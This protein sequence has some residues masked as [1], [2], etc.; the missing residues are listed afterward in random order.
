MTHPPQ[1][2]DIQRPFF[3][4]NFTPMRMDS[5][6]KKIKKLKKN[7]ENFNDVADPKIV[8]SEKAGDSRG[9]NHMCTLNSLKK[10]KS[11]NHDFWPIF[12]IF[13]LIWKCLYYLMKLKKWQN[14][15]KIWPKNWKKSMKLQNICKKVYHQNRSKMKMMSKKWKK[16]GYPRYILQF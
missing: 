9:V 11:R 3:D 6:Y 7:Q 16:W 5:S 1:L 10:K 2:N 13:V 15:V 12:I 8:E 4:P 14:E